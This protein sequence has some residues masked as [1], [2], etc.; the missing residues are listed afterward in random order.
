M[1]VRYI[2][3]EVLSLEELN[4]PPILK[5]LVMLPQGLVLVVGST[6][7]GKSTTLAAMIDYRN[8]NKTG[9]ILTIE[10]SI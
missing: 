8:Q 7:S 10:D 3:P 9:H 4:L 5:E 6:G 2:K 1:V